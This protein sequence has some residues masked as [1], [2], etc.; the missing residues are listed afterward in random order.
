MGG[1]KIRT[2]HTQR[3]GRKMRWVRILVAPV[4]DDGREDFLDISF[5][6]SYVCM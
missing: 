3:K 5:F 1:T 2:R 6:L 4:V